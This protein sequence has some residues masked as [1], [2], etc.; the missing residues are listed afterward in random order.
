MGISRSIVAGVLTRA[1]ED[2]L[3]GRLELEDAAARCKANWA[4]GHE[5]QQ[6]VQ[7]GRQA[8]ELVGP[9]DCRFPIG[10]P[11]KPGFKFCRQPRHGDGPYFLHHARICYAKAG[12]AERRWPQGGVVRR[13]TSGRSGEND[14]QRRWRD[15]LENAGKETVRARLSMGGTGFGADVRGI[16]DRAPHPDKHYVERWLAEEDRASQDRDTRRFWIVTI[17]AFLSLVAAGIAAVPVI[18]G[19]LAILAP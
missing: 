15:A 14:N 17:I 8:L 19:W 1:R 18:E 5:K 16:V 4:K 6:L 2:G 13:M 7:G 3:I 10:T 12:A 9:R 11:G